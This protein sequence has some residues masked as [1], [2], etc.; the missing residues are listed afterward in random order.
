MQHAHAVHAVVLVQR[1]HTFCLV[2]G[3]AQHGLDPRKQHV[4]EQRAYVCGI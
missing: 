2:L 3:W 1:V 4:Y